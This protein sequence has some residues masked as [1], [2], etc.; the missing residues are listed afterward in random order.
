[1]KDAWAVLY[2]NTKDS[3]L[4]TDKP[5]YLA[6][7]DEQGQFRIRGL[8]EGSYKLAAI[9]DKNKNYLYDNGELFGFDV[10][11]VSIPNN[12]TITLELFT[13]RSNKV[14]IKKAEHPNPEKVL[15]LFSAPPQKINSINAATPGGIPVD[16][17]TYRTSLLKDS[18]LFNFTAPGT[19]DAYK[20]SIYI[21]VVYN[22]TLRDS[23]LVTFLS[24]KQLEDQFSRKRLPLEIGPVLR[25]GSTLPYYAPS[26]NLYSSFNIKQADKRQLVLEEN[27]KPADSSK[28]RIIQANPDSIYLSYKWKEESEYTLYLLKGFAT[29]YYDRA[30]DSLHFMFKTNSKSDYGSLKVNLSGLEQ[31]NYLLQLLNPGG[32][33]VYERMFPVS[34]NGMQEIVFSDVLPDTYRMRVVSDINGDKA[35]TP[36][37]YLLKKQA[38]DVFISDQTIKVIS[39]WDNELKWEIKK[40]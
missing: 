25:S 29:D 34:E 23:S 16:S 4:Y 10:S 20:D 13:E 28:I 22:D 39:D 19:E 32:R 38:E 5:D 11:P 9:A 21:K 14:F 8:K 2:T 18:I 30:S 27:G 37:N 1:V 35:F 12:D 33:V 24:K 15:V 36:G 26:Y 3:I 31:G 17:Y 40:P 6:R 7:S